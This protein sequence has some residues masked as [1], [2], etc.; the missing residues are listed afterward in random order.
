MASWLRTELAIEKITLYGCPMQRLPRQRSRLTIDEVARLVENEIHA[1]SLAP[2]SRLGTET[3]LAARYGA[4][5]PAVREAVRLLVA[6]N[7]VRASR[8]PGGGVFVAHVPAGGLARTVGGALETMLRAGITSLSELLEARMLIEVPLA[9]LAAVRADP[10]TVERLRQCL[11]A[12]ARQSGD[13]SAL[14]A[15]DVCFHDA[16]RSCRQPGCRCARGLVLP[17]AR[18]RA[19]CRDRAG[20]RRCHPARAAPAHIRGGPGAQLPACGGCDAQPPTL[21]R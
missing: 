7:L 4:S 12:G 10:E 11:A 20:C 9:G 1:R 19:R 14:R 18:T 16:G 15:A 17:C 6:A 5:R 2:G 21:H 3:E 8:G 13:V